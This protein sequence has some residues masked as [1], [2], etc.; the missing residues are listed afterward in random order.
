MA[1]H[2]TRIKDKD[3]VDRQIDYDALAN[4]PKEWEMKGKTL[5]ASHTVTADDNS[6]ASF[7]FTTEAYPEILNY[8]HYLVEVV[9]KTSAGVPYVYP[10]INGQ[11]AGG[12]TDQGG[13]SYCYTFLERID[14]KKPRFLA[15]SSPWIANGYFQ[16]YGVTH[17]S[18]NCDS[19]INPF[20]CDA[21]NSIG[22]ASYTAF[23]DEGATIYLF[24]LSY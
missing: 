22:I 21:I 23:A 10:T 4:L 5:I 6:S 13:N 7:A 12:G 9:R 3:G 14:A 1:E 18:F 19:Y 8:K 2:I 24:G 17:N 16:R 11:R 15:H 20:E